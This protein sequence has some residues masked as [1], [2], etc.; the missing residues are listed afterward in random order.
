MAAWVAN[1]ARSG[2]RRLIPGKRVAR[3]VGDRGRHQHLPRSRQRADARR[4]INRETLDARMRDIAV[5][6]D[7]F[8]HFSEVHADA[9]AGKIRFLAVHLL[10]A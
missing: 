2:R 7:S 8:A 10:Q 3:T 5:A 6:G 1:V 4:E 9:H